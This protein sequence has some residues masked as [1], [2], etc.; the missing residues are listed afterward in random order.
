MPARW[1][2][3]GQSTIIPKSICFSLPLAV[4]VSAASGQS[5]PML[6]KSTSSS[7]KHNDKWFLNCLRA[8]FV[9]TTRLYRFFDYHEF[10]MFDQYMQC[11]FH[12]VAALGGNE[13]GP[14][15]DTEYLVITMILVFL[16][17]YLAIIFGEMSLLV[18]MC[19]RKS[20]ELK[21]IAHVES[22]PNSSNNY[23]C[24][25]ARS[26]SFRSRLMWPTR[27]CPTLTWTPTT[28]TA[29]EITL[30]QPKELSMNKNCFRTTITLVRRRCLSKLLYLIK[31][32]TFIDML[33]PS[34]VEKIAIC[35]FEKQFMKNNQL[36][37]FIMHR[38]KVE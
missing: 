29:L 21:S 34:L 16:V 5:T 25:L 14:R 30:W 10:S 6:Q 37:E 12:I 2:A 15:T 19:T 13:V 7:N 22:S 36:N 3:W 20:T 24:L 8:F 23:P 31:L 33:S 35:I 4:L 17:I 38:V 32:K 1:K 18:S 28:R 26:Q 11:L 27:R 9:G